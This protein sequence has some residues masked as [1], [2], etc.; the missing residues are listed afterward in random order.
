MPDLHPGRQRLKA[1][2][3]TPIVWIKM[4][5]GPRYVHP[6]PPCQRCGA[7]TTPVWRNVVTGE[8]RCLGCLL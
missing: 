7:E 5:R 2:K 8:V 6:L 1:A 3:G 4:D